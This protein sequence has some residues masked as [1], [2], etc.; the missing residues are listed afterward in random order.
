M[1]NRVRDDPERRRRG[2][3]ER[4][5]SL[6]RLWALKRRRQVENAWRLMPLA[7][8]GDVA[9]DLLSVAQDREAPLGHPGRLL[10]GQRV[11]SLVESRSVKHLCQ[12]H[13]E[14]LVGA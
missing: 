5:R 6:S 13:T 11:S 10:L 2:R 14:A 8:Q 9:G 3:L 12:F 1:S 7:G 4:S